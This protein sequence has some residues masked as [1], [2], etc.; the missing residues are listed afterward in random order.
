LKNWSM[1]SRTVW[2][3]RSDIPLLSVEVTI[4]LA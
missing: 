2:T 4:V 1:R 3:L